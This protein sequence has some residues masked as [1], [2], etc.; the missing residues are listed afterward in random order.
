MNL[1]MTTL[2]ACLLLCVLTGRARPAEQKGGEMTVDLPGQHVLERTSVLI[3]DQVR[4][5]ARGLCCGCMAPLRLHVSASCW[6]AGC[7][8][9]CGACLYVR[10]CRGMPAPACVRRRPA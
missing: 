4:G 3:D 2:H 6:V 10:M 5:A 9:A 7:V 1:N 8:G